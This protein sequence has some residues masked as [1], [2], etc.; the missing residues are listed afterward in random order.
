MPRLSVAPLSYSALLS[1][2]PALGPHILYPPQH[3]TSH[4]AQST[5]RK[6]SALRAVRARRKPAV[7]AVLRFAVRAVHPRSW[8]AL[9]RSAA[10][11]TQ[12]NAD[13]AQHAPGQSPVGYL[14]GLGGTGEWPSPRVQL[15]GLTQPAAASP[16]AVGH[17]IRDRGLRLFSREG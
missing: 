4:S 17:G 1:L 15:P 9:R 2:P 14:G 16:H 8:G 5:S 12:P 3:I 11:R 7:C 6:F 10:L 13:A